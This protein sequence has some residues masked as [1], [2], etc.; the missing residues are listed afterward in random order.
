M[1]SSRERST[2]A[3]RLL[4]LALVPVLA[5]P[6]AAIAHVSQRALVLLLPTGHYIW[7]GAAAVAAT[8]ALLAFLPGRW[9]ASALG[10]RAA[11][12]SGGPT[13]APVT[14][15][16]A[17]A[18]MVVLILAGLTG[19]RDPLV[20]PLPLA[21][22]TVFWVAFVIL[23]ALLGNLWHFVNPWTGP[24]ALIR[25]IAGLPDAPMLRLPEAVGLWPATAGLFAIFWFALVDL[26][27]DDPARLAR[28]VALWWAVHLAAMI[29]FGEAAWRERGEALSVLTGFLARLAPVGR[30]RAGRVVLALPGARALDGPAPRGTA[31]F[32]LL[33]LAGGSFD[34]L[35][36]TFWWLGRIGINPLEFPGRSAVVVENTAGLAGMWLGLLAVYWAAVWS[37]ARLA[38]GGLAQAA[39]GVLALSLLPIALAYHL[40]HYLIVMLINGQYVLVALS[41]PF[42]TGADLLGLGRHFVT[43]SFLNQLTTVSLI[44]DVQAGVIVAGHIWA[45]ILAHAIAVG[46]W[47][48]GRAAALSQVP[49]AGLMV[50]YTLFGLWLLSTPIG[51]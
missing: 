48:P 41:D 27:P 26:A 17:F 5:W 19:S 20:N 44:W 3:G 16:L 30:D 13:I 47:G 39:G 40:S 8:F 36:E 12:W 24:L 45:V 15:G 2:L 23:H 37:G 7:G 25:R 46:Q 31:A 32:L 43:T 42:G 1:E 11:L 50:V 10:W 22:W 6:G 18:V 9:L 51:A 4:P 33:A 21:V 38:G 35:N 29:V 28:A 14:S 49:L 34:G